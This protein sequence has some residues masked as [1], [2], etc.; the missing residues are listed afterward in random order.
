[1]FKELELLLLNRDDNAIE[2]LLNKINKCYEL[3][4]IAINKVYFEV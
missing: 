1:M 2:I 3:S 4:T